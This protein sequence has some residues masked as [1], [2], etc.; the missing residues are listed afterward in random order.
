MLPPRG[1]NQDNI[2]QLEPTTG[3]YLAKEEKSFNNG[4][5]KKRMLRVYLI[6]HRNATITI[7]I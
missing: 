1:Q 6:C 3:K 5:E 7:S 2:P 4:S